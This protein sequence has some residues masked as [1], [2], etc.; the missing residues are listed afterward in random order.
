[1]DKILNDKKNK[2]LNIGLNSQQVQKRI[3]EGKVNTDSTVHTKS[4]KRIFYDNLCTI[5]NFLN[6]CFAIALVLVGS[7]KNMLFLGVVVCNIII[8]IFQEIRSKITVDKLSIVVSKNVIAF[9]DGIETEIAINEIVLDD[10]IKLSRGNQIPSDCRVIE[11]S[12]S[13]N[14][15]LLTGESDLVTKKKGDELLSG[16]FVSAGECLA[17][18]VNVGENNYVS[19]I[20]SSAKYIKKVNSEIMNILNKIIKICSFIIIPV[21]ALLFSRQIFIGNSSVASAVVS[22]VAALIGM[23]PEGLVLLTSTVLAVSVIR[24]SKNKV[25]VQELFC[26]ESLARVDVLCLDKTGTITCDEMEVIDVIP[27]GNNSLL[28]INTALSSISKSSSDNNSTINAIEQYALNFESKNVVN[29]YPFSSETKS[30]GATLESGETYI[31]GA[32]EFIFKDNFNLISD[33]IKKYENDYRT[34]TIAKTTSQ[35]DG[36]QMPKDLQPI[37]FILIKDKIREEA[38]DTIKYFLEQ[39]VNLKVI[40]GDNVKTVENIAKTSGIKNAELS[41]D[42]TTLITDDDIYHAAQAY[43]VFGRVTPIQKKKL[44]TALKDQGHTVAM[45]G[46]GVNDVLALK[47]AD[48]SVAMAAGSEAARNVAQLVLIDNNFASMPKIVS[49]GRRTI[50]NIQRSA[51]LFIVKTIYSTVLA[52]IFVF[53][54]FQFPFQPIQMS[55]IGAFTIGLPSFVLALEPNHDRVIGNFFY[56]IIS[57]SIPAAITLVLSIVFTEICAYIFNLNIAVVSTMCVVLLS[58]SGILLIIRLSVPFTK[59]RT[60]LLITVCMGLFLGIVVFNQ[61]F[62]VCSLNVYQL[63]ILL[64]LLVIETLLFSLLYKIFDTFFTKKTEKLL[65]KVN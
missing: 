20:H 34:L 65:S 53:I 44:I 43:N 46:D 23:I 45:T 40:S 19:K 1:M 50:N 62:A 2:N 31:I 58:I 52:L 61:F 56:N 4:I 28:E 7:Y 57:K 10:V 14:E 5:F 35:I 54:N 21:G 37:G 27:F 60:A 17:V 38:K 29:F 15:S 6:L 33:E 13:V 25:L 30:S 55:L 9:R 3:E 41:V 51:S 36:E 18:V 24:L 47:E 11:G 64:V 16:S 42:A 26:I 8:G 63:L 39:G 32:G 48:C 59:L 49:E 12:C 22:T